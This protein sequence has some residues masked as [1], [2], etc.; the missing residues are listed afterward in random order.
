MPTFIRV[1]SLTVLFLLAPPAWS[2]AKIP[3]A[4]GILVSHS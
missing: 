1:I 3:A 4:A 2:Q